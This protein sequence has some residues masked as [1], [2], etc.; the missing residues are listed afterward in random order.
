MPNGCSDDE[1]PWN[2]TAES[3][4][5]TKYP[6]GKRK[7]RNGG[8]GREEVG[9]RDVWMC[10]CVHV[11]PF[12]SR[13]YFNLSSYLSSLFS[14]SLSYI[15]VCHAEL[16]AI[17]NKNSA[18]V[19][20]CTLYVALFPC[21]ECAKLII[22]SGITD[23]LYVSDKYHDSDQMIASR[24][25][26]DMAKVNYRLAELHVLYVCNYMCGVMLPNPS[27]KYFWLIVP[28]AVFAFLNYLILIQILKN[29]WNPY[30]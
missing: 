4:L 10:V 15:T 1:L 18:D 20:G 21:N 6:Y 16:N 28:W 11:F 9:G 13:F 27:T 22:Q 17:L 7:G 29:P 19:K 23:I 24:K 5:D 8:I 25:L 3:R 26:L 12:L 30:M 2:R 14:L